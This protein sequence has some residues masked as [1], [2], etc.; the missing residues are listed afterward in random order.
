MHQEL[1]GATFHI[2]HVIPLAKGGGDEFS[3]LA[4]ACPS[5]NLHKADRVSAVDPVSGLEVPLFYPARQSWSDH[6]RFDGFRIK[7]LTPTGRATVSTLDFNH[8]R[9]IRI[10]AAEQIIGL[11]R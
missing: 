6:F 5:C 3:N 11:E 10:R 2:E 7:G 8:A 1:Q 4:L 9:R